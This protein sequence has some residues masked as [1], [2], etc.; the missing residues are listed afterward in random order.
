MHR[1]TSAQRLIGDKGLKLCEAPR[2]EYCALCPTSLDPRANMRQIFYRNRPLRAFGLRNNPFGDHMV[3]VFGEPRLLTGKHLQAAAAAQGAEPLQLVPEPPMAIAHVLDRCARMDGPIAINRDIRHTQIDTQHIVNVHRLRRLNVGSRKQVP[4][5]A[6]EGQITFTA[7]ERQQCL[8]PCATHKWYRLS[9]IESPDRNSRAFVGKDTLIECD[10]T[11]RRERTLRF[12]IQLVGI[13]HFGDAPYR[14]LGRQIE[15][16]PNRVIGQ[17]MDGEL[18]KRATLPCHLA[19]VITRR[20]R[21]HKRALQCMRLFGSG[22]EFQLYRQSHIMSIP[23]PE[24]MCKRRLSPKELLRR[25]S[26]P[27]QGLKPRS[28]Q[29]VRFR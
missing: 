29:L 23:Q 28:F 13:C 3:D 24:H 14:K 21:R 18:A 9:A 10:R 17:P 27:L 4:V 20:V 16:L 19:N 15:R 5:A 7:P 22:Q 8:L 11:Q 25:S 1:H 26:F 6:H 12:L 2:M